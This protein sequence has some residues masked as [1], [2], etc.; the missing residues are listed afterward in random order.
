LEFYCTVWREK[1][2]ITWLPDGVKGDKS[3]HSLPQVSQTHRITTAYNTTFAYN[4]SYF[5]NMSKQKP[6]VSWIDVRWP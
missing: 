2:R 1:T 4:P 5:K 6:E 3:G